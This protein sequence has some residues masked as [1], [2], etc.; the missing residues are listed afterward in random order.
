L[1]ENLMWAQ[2][3]DIDWC[4]RVRNKYMFKCNKYST[5]KLIKYK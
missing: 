2:S 5:C 3:E 4:Q 1:N